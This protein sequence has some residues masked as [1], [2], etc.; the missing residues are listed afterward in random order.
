MIKLRGFFELKKLSLF[1]I[2]LPYLAFNFEKIINSPFYSFTQLILIFVI[3]LLLDVI[4]KWG[5]FK[6]NKKLHTIISL[7]IVFTSIVFFYGLY[8]T[9]FL[10]K[11]FQGHF[12]LLIRG[13]S[14]IEFLVALFILLILIMKKKTID[15]QYLNIF[16]IFFSLI[17]VFTSVNIATREK[18]EEFKSSFVSIPLNNSPV[19][20]IL[21]II[22]DEYTSPDGL[23]QIYKDS[24][25]Y[26][27]SNKLAHKGWII[28]NSFYSFE[29]STIHSLSSLFNFN[30]SKNKQFG[31]LS[32][33]V[34]GTSKLIHSNISDSLEKKKINIINFGIFHLGKHPYLNRLYFYPTSFVEDIM[35]NTIYFT[36]KSNTS[37]FNKSG[38]VS[39]YY[40]METHN[41]YIF[42]HL[43][44]TLR[45]INQ[46]KTFTYTHLYMPHSPMQ[47]NPLFPI[48]TVNNLINYKAY[49]NFTNQKLD[50]LLTSL[51][52]ENKY[53]IILTG[54]HGYRGDKRLNP[55][56]TFTAFYGFNQASIEKIKS[57]Q[58]L[59]SLI[60]G[61]F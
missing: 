6:L 5:F 43:V 47:F 42:N 1:L 26:Q 36:I 46:P 3:I 28:K 50:P 30:L 37:N 22:S 52:K 58:D 27:F 16:L 17:T 23:Y 44:D 11:T 9:I 56:Y 61:G 2:A 41:K 29:I 34:I 12:N 59:G 55:H 35:M 25:I 32:V 48:R 4:F 57:V 7:F 20:P 13:R 21:L 33:E 60:Y 40:T 14:I 31:K 19:K 8:L 10:Q 51:I 53:R 54:D 39:S 18:K 45:T 24:S 49:W 38:F 15:Y